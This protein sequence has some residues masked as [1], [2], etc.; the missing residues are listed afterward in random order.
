MGSDALP[1]KQPSRDYPD[2]DVSPSP[3]PVC[4]LEREMDS[5]C[6]TSWLVSCPGTF[7]EQRET[8]MMLQGK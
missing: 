3:L 8:D 4:T 6:D 5:S 7:N 1:L 2:V